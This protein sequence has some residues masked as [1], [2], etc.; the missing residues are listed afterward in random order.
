L[1][2]IVLNIF[3]TI[4]EM[5][6]AGKRLAILSK[7]EIEGVYGLPPFNEAERNFFFTLDELETK[8]MES[9]NSIESRVHFILPPVLN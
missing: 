1:F 5:T 8:E 6:S 2:L 7:D 3:G 9:K 4:K